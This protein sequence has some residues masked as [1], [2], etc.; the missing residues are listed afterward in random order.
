L[1]HTKEFFFSE[2]KKEKPGPAVTQATPFYLFFYLF[3]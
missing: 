3:L 1:N 2:K